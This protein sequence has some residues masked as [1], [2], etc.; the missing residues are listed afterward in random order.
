[1]V[2]LLPYTAVNPSKR[3][4]KKK[5]YFK[6]KKKKLASLSFS[7]PQPSENLIS[8]V[9]LQHRQLQSSFIAFYRK[10]IGTSQ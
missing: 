1:M 8:E 2:V 7:L 10:L 9:S 5:D 6:G 3:K 4:E